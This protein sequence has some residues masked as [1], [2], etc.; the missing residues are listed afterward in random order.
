MAIEKKEY[1][2][3]KEVDDVLALVVSIVEDIKAKKSA[4]DIA[5][6]NLA[7]LMD[8]ISGADKALDEH[9]ANPGAVYATVGVRV[10][11]L[12]GALLKKAP[13]APAPEAA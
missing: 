6:G 3:A 4:T 9:A 2:C 1:D 12:V 7:G 13:E 10:G 8:A 5:T 11:E